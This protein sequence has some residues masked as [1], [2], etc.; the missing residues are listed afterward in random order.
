L[1]HGLIQLIFNLPPVGIFGHMGWITVDAYLRRQY[2][3]G[4]FFLHGLFTVGIVLCFCFFLFQILVRATAG[5]ARISRKTFSSMQVQI[6]SVQVAGTDPVA[7]QVDRLLGLA[8]ELD[9][10]DPKFKEIR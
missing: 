1:S 3:S 9:K 7:E 6:E 4:D 2:L 5:T 8:A 10:L